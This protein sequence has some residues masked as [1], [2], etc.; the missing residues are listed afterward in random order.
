MTLQSSGNPIKFSEIAAEFGYT[1]NYKLGE[2]RVNDSIAG[3]NWVL[4][5]GI[6]SSGQIKF[7][8][9]Y[10]KRLNIVID[11]GTGDDE[12]NVT[13]TN[14]YTSKTKKCVGGFKNPESSLSN[15]GAKKYHIVL[16][17]DY[18]G[19]TSVDTSVKSGNWS[20][21]NG[22]LLNVYISGNATVYGRGGDGGY[23]SGD[24]GRGGGGGSPGKNAIGFSYS[25]NLIVDSGSAILA[26]GGGGGGGKGCYWDTPND[27][28]EWHAGGGGGGGGRGNP[29]GSGGPSYTS[30]DAGVNQPGA[31]GGAG[32]KTKGGGGGDGRRNPGCAAGGG[33]GGG[34]WDAGSIGG[35][36]NDANAGG[37]NGVGGT[38]AGGAGGGGSGTAI[39]QNSGIT[40]NVTNNGTIKPSATVVT[41]SFS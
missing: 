1:P 24:S 28:L 2:Y 23:G 26:G 40:V 21:T 16:R 29:G 32:S 7:S 14:Y 8:D 34:G 30:P 3:K 19:T 33:G 39:L 20:A 17:K 41:G 36:G 9:F 10:G 6:P 25:S 35:A 12:F 27:P 5:E 37:T 22:G 4:D 31:S 11:S 18:G 38:A 15:Q 13:L